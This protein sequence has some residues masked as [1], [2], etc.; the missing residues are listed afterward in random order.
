ML[1]YQ[2]VVFFFNLLLWI[3]L[4]ASDEAITRDFKAA[5]GM[6]G[7]QHVPVAK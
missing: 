1:V 2:R 6:V 5:L 3:G 7:I 4:M